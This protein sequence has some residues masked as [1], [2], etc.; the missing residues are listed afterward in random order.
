MLDTLIKNGTVVDGT[1]SSRRLAAVGIK[2][3]KLVLDVSLDQASSAR[4]IDAEGLIVAPGFIDMH[5]HSDTTM[6]ED[7]GGESKAHQG[8]TTEVTG[9]CAYSPFP[10]ST[11]IRLA[12]SQRYNWPFSSPEWDWTDLDGWANFHEQQGISLN[13]A[14]QVGQSA[15]RQAIGLNENRYPDKDEMNRM[16]LLAAEAVEQ[17]AFSLSLI[18]I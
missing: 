12:K 10:V 8:V 2:D 16:K 7:P 4:T 15:I 18:H 6:L 3:G 17:G 9:N 5:S 14:P 13:I 1:G 11:D